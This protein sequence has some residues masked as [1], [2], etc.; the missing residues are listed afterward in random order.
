MVESGDI[1]G[2]RLSG[3]DTQRQASKQSRDVSLINRD[4]RPSLTLNPIYRRTYSGL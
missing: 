3:T 4:R 2:F 1:L